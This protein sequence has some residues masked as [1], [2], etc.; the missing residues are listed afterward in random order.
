VD[1]ASL[2]AANG[3]GDG[4]NDRNERFHGT[5]V[6][7]PPGRVRLPIFAAMRVSNEDRSPARIY[8]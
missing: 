1:G 2:H 4:E 3:D 7:L 8:G 6:S 5:K